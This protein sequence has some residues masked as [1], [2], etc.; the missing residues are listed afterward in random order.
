MTSFQENLLGAE[1]FSP[2]SDLRWNSYLYFLAGPKSV[3]SN[4]F[5]NAKARIE[6]DRHFARKFVLEADDLVLRLREPA[7]SESPVPT[8]VVDVGATWA[9]LL[10]AASLSSFLNQPVRKAVLEQIER[11]DAKKPLP[12]R[13]HFA[14]RFSRRLF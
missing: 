8:Q 13:A 10:G 14:N 3:A 11:G 6:A 12:M 1:F 9:G 4:E 7:A 2:E 5:G